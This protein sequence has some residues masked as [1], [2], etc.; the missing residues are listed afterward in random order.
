MKGELHTG[1]EGGVLITNNLII[2]NPGQTITIPYGAGSEEFV[3]SPTD[4]GYNSNAQQGWGPSYMYRYPYKYLWIDI[5]VIRDTETSS[6][7]N[8]GEYRSN[9]VITGEG[10]S[11][12]L[13]LS[14]YK[15]KER[16]GT[17]YL[18]SVERTSP[19]FIPFSTLVGYNDKNNTFPVGYV[20]YQSEVN[21][22]KISFHSDSDGD[23]VD[24]KFSKGSSDPINYVVVY[25]GDTPSTTNTPILNKN[26]NFQT[27]LTTFQSPTHG[28]IVDQYVLKGSLSIYVAGNLNSA[29]FNAGTYSSIIYVSVDAD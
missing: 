18:F 9:L 11:T 23:E 10:I 29:S 28:E 4:L 17:S 26:Q 25:S 7:F 1:S 14:G 16:D 13:Q 5:T 6:N 24:F 3:S 8:N 19:Q 2:V 20:A 22:A 21:S 27:T 12:Q 15:G